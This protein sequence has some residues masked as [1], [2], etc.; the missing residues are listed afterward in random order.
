L[1]S[2]FKLIK[3]KDTG[4]GSCELKCKVG[5]YLDWIKEIDIDP[6]K[7]NCKKCSRNCKTCAGHANNCVTCLGMSD[8][9]GL[10]QFFPRDGMV[11]NNPFVLRQEYGT[12]KNN[13]IYFNSVRKKLMKAIIDPS[14]KKLSMMQP[15]FPT[16][17]GLNP[18]EDP[19]LWTVVWTCDRPSILYGLEFQNGGRV[20]KKD[21]V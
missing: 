2:P 11:T 18:T 14:T 1:L 20:L 15:K 3:A 7:Q 6:R 19:G 9:T 8:L 5:Y 16:D 12:V 17:I 21:A 4:K 13:M 10:T